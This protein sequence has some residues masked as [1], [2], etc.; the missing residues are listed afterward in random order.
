MRLRMHSW[1]LAGCCALMGCS[2]APPL[3]TPLS[4]TVPVGLPAPIDRR[5]EFS[6]YLQRE[7]QAS[8]SSTFLSDVLLLPQTEH[9]SNVP[10]PLAHPTTTPPANTFFSKQAVG[11]T[12]IFIVPGIFGDCVARQSLPF[13]DGV[14]RDG[15]FNYTAGYAYLSSLSFKRIEA[16]PLPGRASSEANAKRLVVAIEREAA[17]ATVDHII[18]LAY[19]KGVADSLH[20]LAV[21]HRE[22]RVPQ[23]LNALVSLAGVVNGT[24]LADRNVHLYEIVTRTM[25]PL[26]CSPSEGEEMQSL[27]K[28][29]RMP[30]LAATALP[31]SLRYYSVVASATAE[32]V[33][34]GLAASFSQLAVLGE[35]NDGQL[36]VSD[37]IIPGSHV[38][39]ELKA[40]HWS[41]LLPLEKHPLLAVR[42]IATRK[43]FPRTQLF[44]ALVMFVLNDIDPP[45]AQSR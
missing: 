43:P 32:D 31:R 30:W 34:P 19:S 18:L 40:D 29:F 41:F 1:L 6:R 25:S 28:G 37:A 13:S 8:L 12:S 21:M 38:L 35:R 7:L 24:V 10:G 26:D 27:R 17:D 14:L 4:A 39:A 11:R 5:A 22:G 2:F 16:V 36:L 33:A 44:S 45:A 9:S 15:A 20:A 3:P 42:S 23:K